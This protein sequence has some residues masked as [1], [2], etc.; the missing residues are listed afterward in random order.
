MPLK[1]PRAKRTKSPKH[2]VIGRAY[3]FPLDTTQ[4]MSDK[5]FNI[6]NLCWAVRNILVAEREENRRAN[7]LLREA[8]KPVAYTTKKE[9]YVRVAQLAKADLSYGAV[10]SQ[11][12]QDVAIRVDEGTNRWLDSLKSGRKRVAPPGP[13]DKKDYKSFTFTQYGFA[14]RL[15]RGMLHLSKIGAIPVRDYRKMRGRPKT[16]TIKFEDGQWWAIIICVIQ[17]SDVFRS[18]A[19]VAELPDTGG[20]PGLSS[21]LTMADGTVF[22]PPKALKLRLKNLR[23]AQRD[24]SRKFEMRKSLYL[25]EQA[26][27]KAEGEEPLPAL[28]DIAY[29][30]RL[31]SQIQKVAKIHTDVKNMRR[32]YHHKI[33]RT[34]ERTYRLVAV[35]EHGVL[36]MLMNRRLA[37]STADRG[38]AAQKSALKSVLGP[39]YVPTANQRPGIGGNSQTCLCGASVPKELKVRVHDCPACGLV[40]PRDV[41]SANIVMQIAFGTSLLSTSQNGVKTDAGN[42]AP[43]AATNS[44][45]KVAGLAVAGRKTK[46]RGGVEG[47]K[48]GASPVSFRV[49]VNTDASETPVKRSPVLPKG[50]ETGGGEPAP[51]AKTSRALVRHISAALP[52]CGEHTSPGP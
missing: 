45:T 40:A 30:N 25:Q 48:T 19:E 6:K 29:S 41:V 34:I 28:C 38:I 7:R 17:A 37:K 3:R 21:L 32:H 22:D 23:H 24:M 9:Q 1:K 10:H 20:D 33:A 8:G 50:C 2:P 5:L 49:S 47:A 35:E 39:R 51:G 14:A 13:I 46:I 16:V 26:R 11:V 27:R 15:K 43:G 18:A 36:F 4:A 31:K 42:P 44:A 12:L 52:A